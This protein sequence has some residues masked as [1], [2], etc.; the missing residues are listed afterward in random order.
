MRNEPHSCRSFPGKQVSQISRIC[1]KL[2]AAPSA[3]P[4]PSRRV[5]NHRGAHG[6]LRQ[7]QGK[8]S[9]HHERNYVSS[10]TSLNRNYLGFYE[11][12]QGVEAGEGLRIGRYTKLFFLP[13]SAHGHLSGLNLI[14]ALGRGLSRPPHIFEQSNFRLSRVT[15][16][17]RAMHWVRLSSGYPAE[18][19]EVVELCKSQPITPRCP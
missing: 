13:C 15:S 8:L 16:A 11:A 19:S 17:C 12:A 6:S 2:P 7:A 1:S 3:H 14:P 10:L 4:E 5:P 18:R 9:A